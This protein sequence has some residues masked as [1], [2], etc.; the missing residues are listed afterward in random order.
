MLWQLA[1]ATSSATIRWISGAH[2]PT[3]PCPH[4]PIAS[5]SS[6]RN[7]QRSNSS[8]RDDLALST[9]RDL[10]V[11]RLAY[12]GL[13][14]LISSHRILFIL[15]AEHYSFYQPNTLLIIDI[16]P[17]SWWFPTLQ[18][19]HV[20]VD[21]IRR[22]HASRRLRLRV[23]S[24]RTR[25]LNRFTRFCNLVRACTALRRRVVC[26]ISNC[27]YRH[28]YRQVIQPIDREAS[29]SCLM[30]CMEVKINYKCICVYYCVAI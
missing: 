13:S 8:R 19:W 12:L 6:S 29:V 5:R 11:V 25:Q 14:W 2:P 16:G 15:P 10:E 17:T 9:W 23:C 24:V 18:A 3:H 27:A 1:P 28:M 21:A 4:N 20:V 7:E 22:Q 26:R 30:L